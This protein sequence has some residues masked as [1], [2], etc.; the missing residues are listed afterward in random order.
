[1]AWTTSSGANRRAVP[2][3]PDRRRRGSPREE[4][5]GIDSPPFRSWPLEELLPTDAED[6]RFDLFRSRLRGVVI[7]LAR[8]AVEPPPRRCRRGLDKGRHHFES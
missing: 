7:I 2:G 1:M 6:G 4:E 5:P 8:V 3:L